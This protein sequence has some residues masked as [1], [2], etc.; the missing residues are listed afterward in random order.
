[1]EGSVVGEYAAVPYFFEI[2]GELLQR[3]EGRLG[4]IYRVLQSC[5]GAVVRSCDFAVLRSQSLIFLIRVCLWCNFISVK[6]KL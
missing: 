4:D 5:G 3:R 2:T 1:M 6:V